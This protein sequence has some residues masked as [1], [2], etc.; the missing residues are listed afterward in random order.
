MRKEQGQEMTAPVRETIGGFEHDADVD[1]DFAADKEQQAFVEG[2]TQVLE[3][4]TANLDIIDRYRHGDIVDIGSRVKISEHGGSPVSYTIVGPL[5]ASPVHGLISFISP[6]GGS[7]IGHSA[8]EE[9]IVKAP[10]GFY[11]VRIIE[12]S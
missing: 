7:L 10:G 9:V 6:L 2:R 4:F 8:G 12:V 11:P 5:E 1:P 3:L